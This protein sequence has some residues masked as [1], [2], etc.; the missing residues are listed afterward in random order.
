MAKDTYK[1][2]NE[3]VGEVYGNILDQY[4]NPTY[5]LKLFMVR[6]G[7]NYESMFGELNA[8][9]IDPKDI[10][11]LAQTGVTGNVIDDFVIE[12]LVGNGSAPN[13][14]QFSFT[15]KQQGAASFIDQI[16]LARSYL[17]DE[18]TAQPLF[19]LDLTFKGYEASIDDEDDMGEPVTIAGPFRYR[20]RME[21]ISAEITNSGSIYEVSAKPDDATA[22]N[23]KIYQIPQSFVTVGD[24]ITDHV[25]SFVEQYN[26]CLG[27]ERI[28]DVI[29][30]DLSRLL[31]S[32]TNT[33]GDDSFTKILD[34]SLLTSKDADAETANRIRN[35]VWK[36]KDNISRDQ[37]IGDYPKISG[38][39]AEKIYDEDAIKFDA[40]TSI[41]KF[42]ATI[43][44]MCPEFYTKV[45]RKADP[46]DPKSEVNNDQAY[47]SWFRILSTVSS[48]A[49][50]PDRKEFAKKYTYTPILYKTA[51]PNVAIDEKELEIEPENALARIQQMNENGSLLKAYEYIFT[52]RND[53]ILNLD[54]RFDAK[55]GLLMPAKGGAIGDITIAASANFTNQIDE[56]K[57]LDPQS[58]TKD[59]FNKHTDF[60]IE[61]RISDLFS[62]E[63]FAQ[64]AAEQF[65]IAADSLQNSINLGQNLFEDVIDASSIARGEFD[66]DIDTQRTRVTENT[67]T[68][69][70]IDGNE[71]TPDRSGQIYSAD[72]LN[73]N[74]NN[75]AFSAELLE[76]GYVTAYDRRG[77]IPRLTSRKTDI[78]NTTQNSTYKAGSVRNKLF[79]Y[80]ADQ[81]ASDMFLESLTM[82]VRGDPWYLGN[83]RFV[84]SNQRQVNYNIVENSFWLEIRTPIA[85]DPD[86]TDEDSELNSGYWTYEGTSQTFTAAYIIQRT[87]CSF[88]NG[89]FTVDIEAKKT[90]L[91]ATNVEKSEETKKKKAK[92][93]RTPEEITE[94]EETARREVIENFGEQ[95]NEF[96]NQDFTEPQEPD[97]NTPSFPLG[98]NIDD[99]GG[100]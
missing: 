88:S 1:F 45:T 61:K 23:Q 30:F 29:E 92:D 13:Q 19:F 85:Y 26:L 69:R 5:N 48:I 22:F 15:I 57:G 60:K 91:D 73:P 63:G 43:L 31:G 80:L 28:P 89:T 55:H 71:Y 76:K 42:F 65:G 93:T 34:E 83:G 51:N 90:R 21:T 35:E 52:G 96:M 86:H 99:P 50:D 97:L 41:D 94:A 72:I 98:V 24:S 18:R 56:N 17:G 95:F 74:V 46:L 75:S 8:E 25:N 54:L 68:T 32:A 70:G 77:S 84:K 64:S 58:V 100:A 11:V 6:D 37:S 2:M 62:V 44:S 38:T 10:V 47:V 9:E 87:V 82:T 39:D 78:T 27:D 79:G 66:F 67:E 59:L 7:E 40:G 14:N 4:H 49:Y 53:Q 20:M 33:S 36:S 3:Y 16:I 81:N 12:Q